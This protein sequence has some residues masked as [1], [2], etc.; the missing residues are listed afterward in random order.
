MALVLAT[1]QRSW[2]EPTAAAIFAAVSLTDF[3]DGYLAR[4]WG[5]TSTLGTFLDT[6]ADKLLV[7]GVLIALVAVGRASSWVC[8]VIV[9]RELVI[10]GVRAVVAADGTVMVPSIWGKL[11]ANVQ[12]LAIL[13]AILNV[14]RALGPLNVYEWALAIAAVV[15]AASG[16]DYLVHFWPVLKGREADASEPEPAIPATAAPARGGSASRDAGAGGTATRSRTG[17]G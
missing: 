17:A 11:K 2:A 1:G 14:D 8:F 7:S 10:M 5:E 16:I 3:V 4:R 9:G 6:T 12:F 13:L 15:T